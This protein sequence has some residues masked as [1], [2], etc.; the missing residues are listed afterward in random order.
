MKLTRFTFLVLLNLALCCMGAHAQVRIISDDF[1]TG[2]FHTATA[3]DFGSIGRGRSQSEGTWALRRGSLTNAGRDSRGVGYIVDVASLGIQS[4]H[5]TLHLSFDYTS[6]H[7]SDSL[8]VHIYGYQKGGRT[9]GRQA[10]MVHLDANNGNAWCRN[11]QDTPLKDLFIITNFVNGAAQGQVEPYRGEASGAFRITGTAG[12]QS[13]DQEF[14]LSSITSGGPS[15]LAGY[16]YIALVFTRL[17]VRASSNTAIDNLNLTVGAS[18]SDAYVDIPE[19]RAYG[20]LAGFVA[21]SL[22]ALRR[23]VGA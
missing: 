1:S 19:P 13:V 10:P 22:V 5:D 2:S 15:Q 6:S 14:S 11:D 17:I 12:A 16:D 23:R 9:P 4:G 7:A 20:L 3:G 8:F 21:F 18:K